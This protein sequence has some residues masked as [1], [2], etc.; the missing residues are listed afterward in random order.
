MD[1]CSTLLKIPRAPLCNGLAIAVVAAALA[2]LPTAIPPAFAA[3]DASSASDQHCLGCHGSAGMEKKL[4]D[5]GTLLLHVP[6][7]MFAK[8][9]HR[10]IGC[11]GCH[12]DIDPAAHP[13]ANKD[14]ASARSFSMTMTQVCRGCHADKFDQWET[15]IHAALVRSGNSAAPIC[16]DCHNPHAVIKGAAAEI[17]QIPCQ[18]CHT[19]IY[20]AY[21]GSVHGQA[22]RSS[23]QS[24]A[25]ICFD[26]H[27]AHDVK[28]TSHRRGSGG[29]L[30]RLSRRRAGSPPDMASQCRFAFRGGVLSR[31]PCPRGATQSRSHADRQQG[32]AAAWDRTNRRAA[33]QCQ[34]PV[35]RQRDRRADAVELAANVQSRRHGGKTVLRGRLDVRT[36]RAGASTRRQEQGAQRLPHLS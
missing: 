1:G 23:D 25:P 21:L 28:P 3:D 12:S 31:L 26:C 8:S 15:S 19:A 14:I 11:T 6:A 13:P 27:S 34:R 30:F 10:A 7:D 35:R 16:T 29:G 17:D 24:Y 20:T 36:G 5:G 4:E 22:R 18:K 33:V 2:L 32:R 9:V